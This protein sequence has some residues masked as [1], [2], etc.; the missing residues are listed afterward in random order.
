MSIRLFLAIATSAVFMFALNLG[1]SVHHLNAANA[2]NAHVL[3]IYRDYPGALD[4]HTPCPAAATKWCQN[5]G[6]LDE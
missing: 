3:Q 1:L 4:R 5:V 6:G 2:A